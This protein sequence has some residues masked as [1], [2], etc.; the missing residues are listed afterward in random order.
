MVAAL[1]LILAAPAVAAE[2]AGG[3][4]IL[5]LP[6]SVKA[7]RGP[8]SEVALAVS[9]S[10]LLPIARP[11]PASA[12]PKARPAPTPDETEIA[13]VAVVWGEGGGAVLSL[14]GDTVKTTLIGAEAM[15]G[16]AA[17]ET[18]RG[19]VPG[20]RR[21]LSG[22]LSAYLS[23]PTGATG[24][25]SG[26]TIRER[27]PVGTTSEPTAV[28]VAS[29]TLAPGA[30]AVFAARR[31][32][33]ATIDG[34]P[35]IVAVTAGPGAVSALVLAAK[36]AAGAWSVV[37][38]TPPQ[39]GATP[40]AVAGLGDFAGSGRPQ[41]A[42]IREPDGVGV[43]Q[44]WS[45]ADGALS[46]SAEAPGYAGPTA[47]I[48]LAAVIPGE[49]GQA[50]ALALPAADRDTLAIVSLQGG[51]AERARILLPGPAALGVAVLGRGG[52]ARI[53]VGLADGRLAVIPANAA[54]AVSP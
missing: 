7:M 3:V 33:I 21:A 42:T 32:R 11:K 20:S 17:S 23:G 26:L 12:D 50:A 38:R 46:L 13:P 37:A 4:T 34:T 10:G 6:F 8:G 19:A 41:A 53:L 39:S 49:P 35:V 25:A 27:Q 29:A 52:R 15:E 43:L 31:P 22:P 2:P 18:P 54:G 5:D 30:D 44:L 9:T 14:D 45:Y 47:E 51:I 28:P 40:L 1:L 36:D 16:L 24:R 48:D